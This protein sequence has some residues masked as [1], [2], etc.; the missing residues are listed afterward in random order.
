[1]S[2]GYDPLNNASEAGS[3]FDDAALDAPVNK[4]LLAVR[5]PEW[6]E[7]H[8]TWRWLLDSLEG[9]ERYRQAIYGM[10]WRGMP[11]R[12]LLRHKREYP[13]A[14]TIGA[15][16]PY[17]ASPV[18]SDP[19]MPAQDDDYE[20]RRARTPVPS[21]VP[22]V[23]SGHLGRIYGR[24]IRRDVPAGGAFDAVRAWT[25]DVDGKGLDLD[26]FM[27]TVAGPLLLALGCIDVLFCHPTPPDDAR[28]ETHADEIRLGLFRVVSRLILPQN[29]V[30]WRLD[31]RGGYA[32]AVVQEWSA[33]GDADPRYQLGQV[34]ASVPFGAAQALYRPEYRVRVWTPA[35]WVL[36][37]AAGVKLDEAE[38]PFGAVPIVRLFC[39][40]KPRCENVG[41]SPMASIAE[42]QREYY[43]RDSE[44][45]LSDVLQAHPILQAPEDC[46]TAEGEIS[47]GPGYLLPKKKSTQ[48][49]SVTYEG[50]D[51]VQFPKDG[52]AS[53]RENLASIRDDV[54][55]D[56]GVVK[57]AGASDSR[58]ATVAQSGVSKQLD[59]EALNDRL[60]TLAGY[61]QTAETRLFRMAGLV[62]GNGSPPGSS[63]GGADPVSVRY[64][65]QFD[66]RTADQIAA[67]AAEFQAILAAAGEAPEAESRYLI[68][69]F[70]KSMPGLEDEEYR[71]ID[72]EIASA[73]ASASLRREQ[74][75]ES[76]AVLQ[77]GL[78]SE[79]TDEES[80]RGEEQGDGGDEF[81]G[82]GGEQ[83][84][85]V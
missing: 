47:I 67:A 43:N 81:D 39:A 57:P 45:I 44:L 15:V 16:G 83:D 82:G 34:G 65:V 19:A 72:E 5:H 24:E 64:P 53:I 74:A 23:V 66:F 56:S 84:R 49:G 29:M 77:R 51:V 76:S 61:L 22:E 78:D 6:I 50:W 17:S 26:Q 71:A 35:R 1:M 48:G 14:R 9:G 55:R 54:D 10:D 63:N 73:V 4:D 18:G 79:P 40:R 21:F 62:A 42:K 13:A 2:R 59:N 30:Y 36:Y 75:I 41:H 11:V 28:I 31:A 70:R 38:H 3:C 25:T 37:D 85:P 7:H 32:L 68:E 60:R 52:A 80:E 33:G 12:N 27:S 58:G 46:I 69:L 20:M 8:L